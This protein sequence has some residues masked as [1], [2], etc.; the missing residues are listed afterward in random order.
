MQQRIDRLTDQARTRTGQQLLQLEAAAKT[1]RN[2]PRPPEP[3]TPEHVELSI[4]LPT[5]RPADSQAVG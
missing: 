2:A 1:L 5:P 3:P 4:H